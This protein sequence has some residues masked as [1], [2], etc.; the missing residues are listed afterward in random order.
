MNANHPKT[1]R[2]IDQAWIEQERERCIRLANA[3]RARTFAPQRCRFTRLKP[4]HK[5]SP[6]LAL[7]LFLATVGAVGLFATGAWPFVRAWLLGWL[8]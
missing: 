5:A 4:V 2:Q 1:E 6:G 7:C 8:A 3:S